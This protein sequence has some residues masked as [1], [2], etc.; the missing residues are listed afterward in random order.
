MNFYFDAEFVIT[1]NPILIA[2]IAAKV[3]HP[4]NMKK[5]ETIEK[6]EKEEKANAIAKKLNDSVFDS[7]FGEIVSFSCALDDGEVLNTYRTDKI[8]EKELLEK[9]NEFLSVC[10][11]N[12]HGDY[13][14]KSPAIWTGHNICACDLMYL[15][16]RMLVNNVR[17]CVKIP[18]LDKPWS[19]DVFD[20]RHEWG[21]EGRSSMDFIMKALG[22]GNKDDF[23]GSMVGQ[24]WLDGEYERIA[25]YN[26]LEINQ[27]RE[28]HKRLTFK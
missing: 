9:V 17:P 22:I 1:T 4:K 5:A 23:D 11:L 24:A 7:S 15:W 21:M 16:K 18:H 25:E 26:A 19:N 2:E 8:S 10:M 13:K 12:E 6:W 14:T 3:S 28:I 27:L 20:I